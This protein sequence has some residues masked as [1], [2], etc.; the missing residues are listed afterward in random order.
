MR[1]AEAEAV[2]VADADAVAVAVAVAD[3]VATVAFA[4]GV[5]VMVPDVSFEHAA[6]DGRPMTR[7][8]R[9]R[10]WLRIPRWYR[11][12]DRG[13]DRSGRGAE[14]RCGTANLSWFQ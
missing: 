10:S 9:A 8:N 11:G 13:R 3:A 7:R 14:A 6:I 4:E 1:P 5:G 12:I 2:A